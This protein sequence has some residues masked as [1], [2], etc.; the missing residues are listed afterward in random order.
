[1]ERHGHY[2]LRGALSEP[3]V[4]R[5]REDVLDVYRRVR[6][7]VR[8]TRSP[9]EAEMFRYEMFNRSA[10]CQETIARR[11]LL[12]VVEPLLGGDCHVIAC[13]AWRNPPGN[14]VG[15]GGLAW[16]V[17]GGPH[18]PRGRGILWPWRIPYPVFVVATHIYLQD[19]GQAEGPTAFVPGS[20]TSGRVPPTRRRTA[21][22]MWYRGRRSVAHLAKAG[23]VSFFVSDVWHR[24]LSPS[25]SSAG[26]FFLQT[27]Y[28]RREIAQRVRPSSEVSH[29]SP[30]AIARA[31]TD[32]ERQLIG[33]HEMAFYDG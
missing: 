8:A 29:A 10:L 26:R 32:R 27:N 11:S 6:P 28:A 19:V 12:D 24:R 13:T 2:L 22:T 25:A 31:G 5:L 30:E 16:H 18:V 14:T 33:L 3:E 15:A 7:D 21:E 23:D 4:A 9:Q 17:D 1:L 20:H